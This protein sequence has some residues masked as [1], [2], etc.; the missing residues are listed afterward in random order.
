[1][2]D[3]DDRMLPRV[4]ALIAR[5]GISA[6]YRQTADEG[7]N[8]TTGEIDLGEDGGI[9]SYTV[10]V[11]PLTPVDLRY[12]P[13]GSIIEG[14]CQTYIAGSGL[15]FIPYQNDELQ[16]SDG[17]VW[18]VVDVQRLSSGDSVAAWGLTL[19]GGHTS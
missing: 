18:K 8:V 2:T 10:T 7:F 16:T 17:E 1:M 19:S 3:L 12:T 15:L 11:S 13:G 6:T 14:T 4:L 9:T 5:N